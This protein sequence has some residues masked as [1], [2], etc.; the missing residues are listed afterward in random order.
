MEKLNMLT[1][2][3]NKPPIIK[4][5]IDVSSTIKKQAWYFE[6]AI[7]SKVIQILVNYKQVFETYDI[8]F[9]DLNRAVF[10]LYWY[11]KTFKCKSYTRVPN[12]FIVDVSQ[13]SRRK[14]DLILSLLSATDLFDIKLEQF[15]ILYKPNIDIFSC[16]K[17]IQKRIEQT[18]KSYVYKLECLCSNKQSVYFDD[19][20]KKIKHNHLKESILCYMFAYSE[21]N[22][23][24]VFYKT[25]VF[26]DGHQIL[27]LECPTELLAYIHNTKPDNIRMYMN[28]LCNGCTYIKRHN[29]VF[30]DE[31]VDKY[32][33]IK[34]KIVNPAHY[35]NRDYK[36]YTLSSWQYMNDST[37]L[38]WEKTHP[39][40]TKDSYIIFLNNF[41]N[42]RI[43]KKVLSTYEKYKQSIITQS[44]FIEVYKFLNIKNV[45]SLQCNDNLNNTTLQSL[46]FDMN[47]K[48]SKRDI[49]KINQMKATTP[50][51]GVYYNNDKPNDLDDKIFK[52][53]V[54]LK[55]EDIN[56]IY[57]FDIVMTIKNI[58]YRL[59]NGN[60]KDFKYY[61]KIYKQ[62]VQELIKRMVN[63]WEFTL[64]TNVENIRVNKFKQ[65][66][67]DKYTLNEYKTIN[68]LLK[69]YLP[70]Y[71][72]SI[73][74]EFLDST[75]NRY[76]HLEYFYNKFYNL[77]SSQNENIN[78]QLFFRKFIRNLE[79]SEIYK[80]TSNRQ[81]ILI[82]YSDKNNPTTYSLNPYIIYEQ[83]KVAKT[84]IEKQKEYENIVIDKKSYFDIHSWKNYFE[85]AYKLT[86]TLDTKLVDKI[87]KS[88]IK[89][90][91]KHYGENIDTLKDYVRKYEQP[92][93]TQKD[94]D[95]Y[96]YSI[97]LFGKTGTVVEQQI[98][99][100]KAQIFEKE[101]SKTLFYD[102]NI[103]ANV[104]NFFEEFGSILIT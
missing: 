77:V 44:Q 72:E 74:S 83:F 61:I 90:K 102:N 30:T 58:K 7:N 101:H 85:Y 23:D 71:Y 75:L 87:K 42:C 92:F 41:R 50:G 2:T 84:D 43:G 49:N 79:N 67:I 64:V 76:K 63:S 81:N 6:E 16:D 47:N 100:I 88:L 48:L 89:F 17:Y 25:R 103:K 34:S 70:D 52:Q 53:R 95:N 36:K 35:L 15:Y 99:E 62:C 55:S 51:V 40:I 104:N 46:Q 91:I 22:S 11:Y 9:E 18:H 69:N 86:Q 28:K 78:K 3:Y 19:Y 24:K 27:Y 31:R 82:N 33:K 56:S 29:K 21:L 94:Y 66:Q 8:A 10:S 37:G 57:S 68:E 26:E 1:N 97:S 98:E 20:N 65:W 32:N 14:V 73:Y 60:K 13:T 39:R 96:K 54:K 93:T 38:S 80:N 59:E 5:N 12:R 45:Y 4:N